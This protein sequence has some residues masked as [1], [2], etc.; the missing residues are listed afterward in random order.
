[1]CRR[2]IEL[3]RKIFIAI[4]FLACIPAALPVS[5][6]FTETAPQTND[7]EQS[8]FSD[9]I[10]TNQKELDEELE[11]IKKLYNV[12]DHRDSEKLSRD[13]FPPEVKN[14]SPE[15]VPPDAPMRIKAEVTD[16]YGVSEVFVYYR[17]PRSNEIYMKSPMEKLPD[18]PVYEFVIPKE[19]MGNKGV[20]YYIEASDTNGNKSYSIM[21]LKKP[22]WL[23][24]KN[25][26]R[27]FLWAFFVI[28]II[29]IPVFYISISRKVKSKI[30][31]KRV[32]DLREFI[33][34]QEELKKQRK[35]IYQ[36]HLKKQMGRREGEEELP[37]E[38]VGM[39][40]SNDDQITPSA[41][42]GNHRSVD[43]ILYELD[44]KMSP[45]EDNES[46][47]EFNLEKEARN[48]L[49]KDDMFKS[50]EKKQQNDEDI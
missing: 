42:S 7:Y 26:R 23:A 33:D 36:R 47:A 38:A 3:I 11:E 20:Q 28:V 46:G 48:L 5:A 29:I 50:K 12:R 37:Q 6:Q 40:D 2:R 43:D 21:N 30:E 44:Q 41:R 1:M 15:S 39:P 16:D 32:M 31:E 4:I 10:G 14:L 22:H 25:D 9:K 24:I 19:L 18:E 34:R 8:D 49:N 27:I 17:R 35:K 13:I 45:A